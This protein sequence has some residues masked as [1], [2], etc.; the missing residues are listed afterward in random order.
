MLGVILSAL[1]FA[2]LSTQVH[3]NA[4]IWL[5]DQLK[6]GYQIGAMTETFVELLVFVSL[7]WVPAL[8][9]LIARDLL[10]RR[11][12]RQHLEGAICHGCR[13]SLIGLEI[14]ERQGDVYVLCP[15]CGDEVILG[16]NNLT[17]ADINPQLLRFTS[18]Q[19]ASTRK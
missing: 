9:G 12:V 4:L 2:I 18:C 13:Y 5:A 8:S 15:E 17:E 1:V 7:I 11:C 14:F 3:Y 16:N 19:D 6:R 10:L